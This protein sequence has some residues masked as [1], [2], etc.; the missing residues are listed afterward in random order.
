M[1]SSIDVKND[2]QCESDYNSSTC[3]S[4]SES[5]SGC[6]RICGCPTD[7]NKV[8]NTSSFS[9]ET[10]GILKMFLKIHHRFPNLFAENYHAEYYFGD[11]EDQDFKKH[12]DVKYNLK[13]LTYT[14]PLIRQ[15]KLFS[16]YGF[17]VMNQYN[18]AKHQTLIIGCGH[19]PIENDM[20]DP[21]WSEY[22]NEHHHEGCYTIDP[23][24]HKNADIIGVYGE[25]KFPCLKDETFSKIRSE[26]VR[27]K[28]TPIFMS[29]TTRLLKE[30]GCYYC[31][32]ED[33]PF[34]IKKNGKLLIR[35]DKKLYLGLPDL[36]EWNWVKEE[37]GIEK[38]YII[39]KKINLPICHHEK[40]TKQI[41]KDLFDEDEM[42]IVFLTLDYPNEEYTLCKSIYSKHNVIGRT[43]YY[44]C[45]KRTGKSDINF[46]YI[47]TND[48]F[49]PSKEYLS[50][51]HYVPIEHHSWC[52]YNVK[53]TFTSS[54]KILSYISIQTL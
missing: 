52:L 9:D 11:E 23:D 45:I 10:M 15:R 33:L 19:Y 18:P 26:G 42:D 54:D 6:D 50:C 8:F 43:K 3:E 7:N 21:Y 17:I 44:I 1:I 28:F 29:E 12:Y 16:K 20:D 24:L 48:K 30:G 34:F 49:I 46:T 40:E 2:Y 32:E 53:I 4:E 5:D 51:G 27:L 25:Q 36:Q 35:Q 13:L 38:D 39:S 47:P 22:S 14:F 41:V 31:D 37:Y